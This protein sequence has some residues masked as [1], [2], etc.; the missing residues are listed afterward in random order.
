MIIKKNIRINTNT[1]T[2]WNALT[3]PEITK[4][5]MYGCAVISDWKMGSPIY[6]NGTTE[7]GQEITYVKGIIESIDAPNNV[8]FT[9]F[10]PNAELADIPENYVSLTYKV[11][12]QD[13]N[14]TLFSLEQ[15]DYA[16]VEN[17]LKRYEES[18][19]GWDFVLPVLKELVEKL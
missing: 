7:D 18:L 13:E 15:G 11:E 5:Y 9:M 19:Q 16:K 2:V 8:Q 1:I 14:T 10:D 12:A 17:S 6:W 4:Q 3:N